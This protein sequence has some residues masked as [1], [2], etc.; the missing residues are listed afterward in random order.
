MPSKKVINDNYKVTIQHRK[1]N[2]I[3]C[4]SEGALATE[5]SPSADLNSQSTRGDLSSQAPQ[6]DRYGFG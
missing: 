5:E 6:D 4:H 3:D 1:P 2:K